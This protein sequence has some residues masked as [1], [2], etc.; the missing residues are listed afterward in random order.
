MICS[1]FN[2]LLSLLDLEWVLLLVY[3]ICMVFTNEPYIVRDI[4]YLPGLGNSDHVCLCFS[5]L[6]YAHLKDTRVLRYNTRLDDY[7]SMCAT[8][9]D[10]NWADIMNSMNTLDAWSYF[11]AIFQETID[12]FVPLSRSGNKKSTYNSVEAFQLRKLK[13]KLWKRYCLSKADCDYSTF[14]DA[15]NRLRSHTRNLRCQHEA[16]LVSNIANIS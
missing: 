11:R 9:E 15:S 8:L 3:L 13:S 10:I 6:C 1:F 14:R 4:S 2:M 12:K 16:N 7:D 5:L